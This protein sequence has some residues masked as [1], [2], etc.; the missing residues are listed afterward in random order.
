MVF[1]GQHKISARDFAALIAPLIICA[2]ITY[3]LIGRFSVDNF[4]VMLAIY[5]A[6]LSPA[7][8]MWWHRMR[9]KPGDPWKF[10]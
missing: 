6:V 8:C 9:T 4:L 1:V 7:L 3:S 10:G 2:I 5:V